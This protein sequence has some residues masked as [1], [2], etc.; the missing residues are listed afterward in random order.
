LA[1]GRATRHPASVRRSPPAALLAPVAALA[2]V[3]AGCGDDAGG[4]RSVGTAEEP[5]TEF[6]I[7]AEDLR[8]DLDRVV[9][10]AGEEVTATIDNRDRGIGHNLSVALPEGEAKTEVEAGPVEQTLRFTV[11]EP[12]EY[13]FVCDPHVAT[14]EGVIEAV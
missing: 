12:G 6:T 2:V 4:G 3:V 11:P 14:M 9:V 5:V 13:D 8:F 7:V 10:P 1:F